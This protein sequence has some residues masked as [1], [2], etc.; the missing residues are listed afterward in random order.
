MSLVKLSLTQLGRDWRAGELRLLGLALI[1]A[2]ASLTSVDFFTD[3]VSQVTEI[4]ATELL[5]ADLV[6]SSAEPISQEFIEQARDLGLNTAL[7]VSFRS[8]A[9]H[10]GKL[11]L[12]QVKAVQSGYPLR[13]RLRVSDELFAGETV[14]DSIPLRGSVWLDPRL[15]Q[16]LDLRVGARIGLGASNLNASKVLTY[17]PDR[18]GDMF[19][20]APRLLMNLADL[21][22]TG[23]ILPGSRATYRLLLAGAD[24]AIAGFRSLV[25]KQ[26]E[27][28]VQGIRDA[29]PE[30][31]TAL[32]R[33]EQFLGLAV[34]VSIALAGLAIAL[35]AQHYAIRHYDNCA[36]MRCFGAGPDEVVKLYVIQLL[37]TALVCS[38]IG[39][40]LGY[41][42]QTWLTVLMRDLVTRPL[43]APSPVPILSGLAAGVLTTLGFAIPQI[44]RLKNVSPLR[45]LRRDLTP[46]PLNNLGI[47]LAAVGC[48]LLLVLWQSGNGK[49]FVYGFCGLALTAL[50]AFLAAR[51]AIRCLNRLRAGVGVAGRF[52]LMNIVRRGAL[53]TA[54]I[55]AVSLGV[56][57]LTLL[58][59]IRTDLLAN[60]RARL[61][62]DTPNYFL[63]NIQPGEVDAVKA[64][65][66]EQAGLVTQIHPL[67]RARLTAI[68]GHSVNPDDYE[69]ERAQHFIRRTFNLS[70]AEAL[71]EDNRLSAGEWWDAGAGNLFSFEDE[72]AQTLDIA[73]GDSLEFSIADK[74]VTGTVA[75]TRWVDWDTFNVNFFVV[76]N[77]G[78]LDGHPT[79]YITSFFLPPENKQLLSELIR[80]WPSITVFDVDAILRQVRQIMQQVVRAVE[81][82]SGFTLL[83]GIIVLLAALQ[84][85]H[86]E[87]RYET[88][89]LTTLGAE[90]GHILAGL[91][92]EFAVLG[93]IAGLIAALNASMA[94]ILL[95]EFVFKIDISVN[96]WV[97]LITPLLC[98]LVIVC[99]GLAGTYKVLSTP[100]ALAL[101]QLSA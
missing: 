44:L 50:T 11:E 9:V 45:V 55:L 96:P 53:S 65:I 73:L 31:R 64:F 87:R 38:A 7:T 25:D 46:L 60:W 71:Q 39:C 70:I 26:P 19:N 35:S 59:L 72:F 69:D 49:L 91:L 80:N 83:A 32:D 43:P 93:L 56:M 88:A 78:T 63:I 97:W 5:A 90:R 86:D 61:P 18:G 51:L 13:G 1:I 94:E 74:Q 16:L 85:T 33:A 101:R 36:I 22:A 79:T 24:E 3:R 77:P 12:A 27:Y 66:R 15:F 4:Q 68:N 10:G 92:A 8:V 89:L 58:V 52:G 98:T 84:T 2:V 6:I 48:L 14:S 29:R 40:G 67:V 54:Q 41:L 17:E 99:A 37:I 75:N 30:L 81:F 42:G 82:I 28:D 20:I 57:V 34:L 47:Y 100:P 76:A 95:A 62:A 23:L 21:E